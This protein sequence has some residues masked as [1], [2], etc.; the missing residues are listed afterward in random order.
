MA[1][2]GS[3]WWWLLGG[4]ALVYL[5]W[6]KAAGATTTPEAAGTPAPTLAPTPVPTTPGLGIR[7]YT[8]VSG[9]SLSKIAVGYGTTWQA[10]YNANKDLISDPNLIYPGQVLVIP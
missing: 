5:I 7:L 1:R 3:E 9:D 10:I 2:G 8:V 6:P 4:A